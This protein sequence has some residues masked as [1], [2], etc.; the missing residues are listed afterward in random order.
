MA[1]APATKEPELPPSKPEPEA[2][3]KAPA[4]P[5]KTPAPPISPIKKEPVAP[6]P[7]KKVP[8]PPPS[9]PEAEA[10]P[11]KDLDAPPPVLAPQ[12][13]KQGEENL[14]R[15]AL[16]QM[17][18]SEQVIGQL[19]AKKLTNEQQEQLLTVKGLLGGAREALSSQDLTKASNLAEKA[20]I[21]A[22]ELAQTVR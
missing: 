2:P 6:A 5:I 19:E 3:P 12:V 4:P 15:M 16:S 14:R 18:R 11:K 9:K 8:G 21:L 13:G 22:E 20:R 7:A 1:P 17:Q 10:P